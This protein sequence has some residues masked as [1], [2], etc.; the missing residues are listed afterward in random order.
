M[1]NE[2]WVK[3][4]KKVKGELKSERVRSMKRAKGMKGREVEK[5]MTLVAHA[6]GEAKRFAPPVCLDCFLPTTTGGQNKL[7]KEQKEKD[8]LMR[9]TRFVR[10]VL[11]P[12]EE[13]SR[14]RTVTNPFCAAKLP[15]AHQNPILTSSHRWTRPINDRPTNATHLGIHSAD[16]LGRTASADHISSGGY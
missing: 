13:W 14:V 3:E 11:K 2:G 7:P 9:H 8:S 6:Q 4:R 1:K 10:V 12:H 15:H 16:P 5:R